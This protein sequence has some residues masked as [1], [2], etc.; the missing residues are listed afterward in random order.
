MNQCAKIV[1]S[2]LTA[3]VVFITAACS[4]S[5]GRRPTLEG[6]WPAAIQEI[7]SAIVQI[8]TLTPTTRKSYPHGTAFLVNLDGQL[9]TARHVIT[10][11]AEFAR[12][13]GDGSF[14]A[15]GMMYDNTEAERDRAFGVNFTVV[16]EDEA[17]DLVLLRLAVNPAK[18]ELRKLA[19]AQGVD[20]VPKVSAVKIDS[21]RPTEGA[22]ISVSGFPFDAPALVTNS[23]WV[24]S[25]WHSN[26]V[27]TPAGRKKLDIYIADAA[28]NPGNSGGPVYLIQGV[29]VIGVAV[30]KQGEG[31]A[32]IVP[33]RYVVDLLRRNGVTWS[34]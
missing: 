16:A 34:E 24:A 30:A 4:A 32:Y 19:Q 28:V 1:A 27:T 14:V 20:K 7:R 3:L 21:R 11:G 33:A 18:G 2:S 23:G 17:N 25:A 13:L 26:F 9:I 22:R 29:R 8:R 12:R 15:A 6:D 5:N 10:E 31:F